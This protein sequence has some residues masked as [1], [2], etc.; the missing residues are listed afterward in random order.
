[1]MLKVA[2]LTV[3]ASADAKGLTC[4]ITNEECKSGVTCCN[5]AFDPPDHCEAVVRAT[6]SSMGQPDRCEAAVR[7][8]LQL[9]MAHH[10]S[11]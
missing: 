8:T 10:Q 11:E 3:V 4:A 6:H 1:M 7:A 5:S 2:L 9:L